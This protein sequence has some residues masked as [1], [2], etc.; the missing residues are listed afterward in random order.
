MC[1]RELMKTLFK[2]VKVVICD[3]LGINSLYQQACSKVGGEEYLLSLFNQ[4]ALVDSSYLLGLTKL[5]W[6]TQATE[7]DRNHEHIAVS[8]RLKQHFH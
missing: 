5:S 6:F 7:K 1:V 3:L 4:G 8:L 2:L